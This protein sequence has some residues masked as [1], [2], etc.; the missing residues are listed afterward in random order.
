M[1]LKRKPLHEPWTGIG[2]VE[3]ASRT[4]GNS[5]LLAGLEQSIYSETELMKMIPAGHRGRT[6]TLGW[7]LGDLSF[8]LCAIQ[9][10]FYLSNRKEVGQ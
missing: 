3:Q 10:S 7:E 1:S 5:S 9:L 6:R 4:L 2:M 8:P